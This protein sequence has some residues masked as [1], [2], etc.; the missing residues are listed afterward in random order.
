VTRTYDEPSV[1]IE[2]N[3]NSRER[4]CKFSE[5][6]PDT[7]RLLRSY[8]RHPVARLSLAEFDNVKWA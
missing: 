7:D 2:A 5:G 4:D 1:N 3:N 8:R 6:V